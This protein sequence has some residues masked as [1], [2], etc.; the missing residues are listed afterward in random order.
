[1]LI[2]A[3]KS[4][5]TVLAVGYIALCT[6]VYVQQRSMQYFPVPA[7]G[8]LQTMAIPAEG[9][10]VH[11]S[12]ANP[13][14]QAA[15]VYFGGNAE[16]VS[17]SAQELA[18]YYPG[19]AV[20]ALHYR[21]YGPS[22]GSPTETDLVADASTLL[23]LAIERHNA[24][25]VVGRSLGSG[26]AV[27]SAVGRELAGLTLVTPF[28]SAVD[29]GQAA[30]WFLPVGLLMHDR[31]EST[32]HTKQLRA[33]VRVIIAGRDEVIPRWSSDALVDSFAG[34]QMPEVVILEGRGHNDVEQDS[35][36]WRLLLGTTRLP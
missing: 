9:V 3:L 34:A 33:P 11:A 21:G 7:R 28:S 19:H 13:Q 1:M 10:E 22:G 32:R 31:F 29:V 16:D 25:S 15:I 4:L 20:Y 23:D 2:G 30:F 26:V 18:A 5:L 6:Y 8:Q 35:S 17:L 12:V 14:S 24:V 27:Q 36:Y